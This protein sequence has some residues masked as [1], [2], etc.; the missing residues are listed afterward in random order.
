MKNKILKAFL[1]GFGIGVVVFLGVKFI[2]RTDF[3]KNLTA[4]KGGEIT[5]VDLVKKYNDNEALADSLYTN[6][7]I[8][9]SGKV[10]SITT[11]NDAT[12]VNLASAD[13]ITFVSVTLKPKQLAPIQGKEIVLKGTCAGKLSDVQITEGEIL[14]QK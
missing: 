14:E 9:I 4:K 8:T 5:A 10:S 6:K 13:S 3:Y 7:Q 1:I 12:I 11:E 2:P